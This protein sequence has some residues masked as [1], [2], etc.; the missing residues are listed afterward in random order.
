ME[1]TVELACFSL[2]RRNRNYLIR[3]SAWRHP[4]AS[5]WRRK[6]AAGSRTG[7]NKLVQAGN[8]RRDCSTIGVS[9]VLYVVQPWRSDRLPTLSSM[10]VWPWRGVVIEEDTGTVIASQVVNWIAAT[11]AVPRIDECLAIRRM[12]RYRHFTPPSISKL[13]SS[14]ATPLPRSSAGS[15]RLPAEPPRGRRASCA[16]C[17]PSAFP[18]ACACA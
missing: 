12:G 4:A 11:R 1:N 18:E 13:H 6:V 9:D 15:G 2:S 3:R 5:P 16:F 8:A 14:V 7:P 17:L 10:V